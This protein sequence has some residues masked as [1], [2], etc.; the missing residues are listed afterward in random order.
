MDW[1]T[2][3]ARRGAE[4]RDSRVGRGKSA[5]P[6]KDQIRRVLDS[7]I[8]TFRGFPGPRDP[9][10]AR[11]KLIES[12]RAQHV[13]LVFVQTPAQATTILGALE[14]RGIASKGFHGQVSALSRAEASRHFARA[15]V[16]FKGRRART[17][18][19]DAALERLVPVV[20]V[21]TVAFGMGVNI[22]H[23]ERVMLWTT[24]PNLTTAIQEGLR[25]RRG[26]DDK[27]VVDV[28]T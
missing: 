2:G 9:A 18:A 19:Q 27:V 26:P 1:S 4:G 23:I 11:T 20:L 6:E 24:P 25:G 17:Q 22:P 3:K 15:A 8:G 28:Y 10:A 16:H 14:T 21:C 13:V 5:R 7:S 12:V